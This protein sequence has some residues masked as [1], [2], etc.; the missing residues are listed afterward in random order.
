MKFRCKKD[1]FTEEVYKF[2]IKYKLFSIGQIY[3]SVG[4]DDYC[5]YSVKT[6][7]PL[8]YAISKPGTPFFD[9]HFEIVGE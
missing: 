9:E 6:N 2:K 5:G 1:C 4:Y 7:I 8:P 3:E